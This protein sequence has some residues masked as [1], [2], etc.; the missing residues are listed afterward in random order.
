MKDPAIPQF[1]EHRFKHSVFVMFYKDW[2][3]I[4]CP[5]GNEL[6]RIYLESPDEFLCPPLELE[7]P[8]ELSDE[9]TE[10]MDQCETPFG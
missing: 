7:I 5:S 4:W 1:Y 2:K 6:R 3:T 10:A 9:L 8:K